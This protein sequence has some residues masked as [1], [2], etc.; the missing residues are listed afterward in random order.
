M[1]IYET[2]DKTLKSGDGLKSLRG[3]FETFLKVPDLWFIF[4]LCILMQTVYRNMDGEVFS[5]NLFFYPF[6]N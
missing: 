6:D 2:L 3:D 5:F 4:S 1:A